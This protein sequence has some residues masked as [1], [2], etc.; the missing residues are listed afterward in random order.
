MRKNIRCRYK[1][2]LFH[3]I[4]EDYGPGYGYTPVT[5]MG[6]TPLDA[7]VRHYTSKKVVGGSIKIKLHFFSHNGRVRC[8]AVLFRS[9]KLFTVDCWKLPQ[10]Y[11]KKNWD[12]WEDYWFAVRRSE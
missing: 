6:E 1:E 11:S 5:Y 4:N 7:L 12:R 8:N 10:Q 3:A 9:G 2:W